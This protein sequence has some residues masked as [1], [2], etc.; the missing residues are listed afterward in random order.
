MD[1]YVSHVV[2]RDPAHVRFIRKVLT[3]PARNSEEFWKR[4]DASIAMLNDSSIDV[5]DS[6]AYRSLMSLRQTTRNTFNPD[7]ERD[8]HGRF[9]GLGDVGPQGHVVGKVYR[10]LNPD[11]DA[12]DSD[13][14]VY[15]GWRRTKGALQHKVM[16]V[17]T[18]DVDNVDAEGPFRM[19]LTSS[20]HRSMTETEHK[21]FDDSL[22]AIHAADARNEKREAGSHEDTDE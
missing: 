20:P 22:E 8:Y 3:K 12:S 17:D 13:E 19:Q 6:A 21:A 11:P 16:F 14:V 4:I 9:A 2:G 5:Y 7:Q 15:M 1:S 18:H 10:D